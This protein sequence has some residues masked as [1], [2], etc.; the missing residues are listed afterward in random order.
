MIARTIFNIDKIWR[1]IQAL[2]NK[3][4]AE[5]QIEMMML[6]IRLIR[7]TTRWFLRS[8]R[9]R[10]NMEESVNFYGPGVAKLKKNM[11]NVLGETNAKNYENYINNYTELGV[12]EKLSHELASTRPLFSALDIIEAANELGKGIE[13]VAK[14]YFGLGEFLDLTWI[15][16]QVIMHPTDNHWEALSREALRDDLDWQQ[17]QLTAGIIRG[18]DKKKDLST[19]ISNWAENYSVLIERWRYMLTDLR[20]STSLNYTM[21]FVA[22]R[23]L[24]DLTQTTIQVSEKEDLI[25]E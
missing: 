19:C 22:I 14:V 3:V 25:N 10:L 15:R 1:D 6:Y 20:A 16:T 12:S 7:R 9:M 24:L 18:S 8:Q 11:L 2:D 13:D 17:R 21:F 5:K 23:E 4:S